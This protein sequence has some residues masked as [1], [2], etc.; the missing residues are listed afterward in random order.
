MAVLYS[1]L[2]G[3]HCASQPRLHLEPLWTYHADS[4]ITSA[5][6]LASGLVLV[7]T[8]KGDVVA[9][10]AA[11]GVLK[12]HASLGAN[13]DELYGGPRGVVGS[14]VVSGSVAYAASGSCVAAAFDVQTG[15]TRWRRTICST[16]RNDDIFAS[17]AVGG[18]LVLI[19]I[20][21]LGDRPTD[22]GREIALDASTGR[23]V[24]EQYPERYAGTGTGITATALIDSADGIAYV[25]TGNPTPMYS[26]PAGPDLYSD[27]I[28]ALDLVTGNI[29]WAH[30]VHA[31][32]THDNDFM[33]SPNALVG[34]RGD[35][36][37]GEANKDATYYAVDSSSGRLVWQR[38]LMTSQPSASII[39]TAAVNGDA[40]FVPV[41]AGKYIGLLAALGASNGEVRWQRQTGGLYGAPLVAENI[42][43]V[44]L[45]AGWLH[46][47]SAGEGCALGAWDLG[48]PATGRGL[49]FANGRLY[50][51]AGSRLLAFRV[52]R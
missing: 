1:A 25:G 11:T 29:R 23:T 10:D 28:L 43:F 52:V 31:H 35:A 45:S 38:Q 7:G 30:Q 48:G 8:W 49:A 51:A 19:G 17:P 12:W 21:I 44:N 37:I 26:P 4:R 22:R 14:V 34:P 40:I 24:W 46:A 50:D 16:A 5:P 2:G 3:N 39:G 13:G 36:L 33:A 27:S 47:Y 9:L 18:G 32:D 41:Y 42:V 15:R 20:S 6:A